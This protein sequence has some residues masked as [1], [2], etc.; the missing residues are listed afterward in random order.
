MS[1]TLHHLTD[2]TGDLNDSVAA[3]VLGGRL[4]RDEAVAH[5]GLELQPVLDRS[6]VLGVFVPGERVPDPVELV[7]AQAIPTASA[8]VDRLDSLAERQAPTVATEA[9]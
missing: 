2:E 5:R 4:R 6:P 7:N 1:D 9:D 8:L 3:L